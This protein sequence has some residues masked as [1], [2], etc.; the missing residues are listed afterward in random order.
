[1]L[2]LKSYLLV[3]FVIVLLNSTTIVNIIMI[4]I[5]TVLYSAFFRLFGGLLVSLCIIIGSCN[6]NLLAQPAIF[7]ASASIQPGEAIS[8]EG[9]FSAKAQAYIAVGT[10]S[11]N[12]S[13]PILV[14][15][16]GHLTAQVPA[17]LT[18]DV[19][20]VWVSDLGQRS[21]SVYINQARGMH[22]NSPE[23]TPGGN[24]QLF[25][26]NLLLAGST[27]QVRFSVQGGSSS[28]MAQVQ[29]V[30][31][32]SLRIT[33][34]SSLQPGQTYDVYVSNG[35]GGTAGETRVDQSLKAIATGVDYFQL[36]VAWA[37][38]LDFYRNIYNIRTDPRLPQKAIGN[39]I[40][41]DLPALQAAV[42]RASADGG[43]IVFLP[44]GIYKLALVGGGG[45]YMRNRVVIQGASKAGTILRYGYG[46]EAPGWKADGRWGLI[47]DS[48]IQGGL[49]DLTLLNIDNTGNFYNN[50]TGRGTEV[51][52][53]RVRFDLNL[54]SWLW[55]QG[56]NKV[57]ISNSEFTQGVDRL[58][59][60]HGLLQMNN[61]QNFV[62]AHNSFTYAVDG[63]NLNGASQGVFEDNQVNRDGSA[64][65]PASLNLVNHVLILNFAED[66]AILQNQFKVINGPAQ[67]IND[68]ET[69]IAEGGGG[70]GTRIDEDAG[71]ASGATAMTLQDNSKNWP[72]IQLHPVVAI[73]RGPGMGQ[74]RRIASRT[75]TTLTVDRAWDVVPTSASRYAIFNWGSRSWIIQGNKMEGNQRGIT[76]Y[77]NATADIAIVDNTLINNGSIDLT[78]W[79]M[80]N[81]GGG[82]P[83]EFLPMYDVQIVGNSV[84]DID[85]SNGVFIGVHTVQYIQPRSFGTSVIGLEV[86]RN[87]LVAH[88]PNVPAVVDAVFPEGYLNDLHFQPWTSN[89]IDE[90]TPAVLG[91]IF[92]DNIA[93][94]CNNA[95]YTNS[96]SYNT[97]V[98]NMKLVN[99]PNLIKD[100][101]FDGVNHGAVSTTSCASTSVSTG[102]LP[103]N[104]DPKTNPVIPRNVSKAR[105][106][107]LTGSD[108]DPNGKVIGFTLSS[109]PDANQGTVLVDGSPAK[110]NTWVPARLAD[111]LTF[112][113]AG[114]YTGHATFTYTATNDRSLISKAAPFVVPIANPLPVELVQFD[115]KAQNLDV[116][117]TWRTASSLGN[118]HFVVERSFD[119]K[120]YNAVGIVYDQGT[121]FTYYFT[122]TSV[123]AQATSTIYYRLQQVDK[124]GTI[125]YSPVQAVAF[126]NLATAIHIYPNP[127]TGKL[128]MQLP[129]VGAHVAIYSTAGQLMLE[130]RTSSIEHTLN[131]EALPAGVYLL[132]VQPDQ[133][134]RNSQLF[135]K[136][137]S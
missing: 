45:L 23:I 68:G 85:G 94:N 79:Q 114:N 111:A 127:T 133:G 71:T 9:Q 90:Q 131:I 8:L 80:E 28:S 70:G 105:L 36:G 33:A 11:V 95:L 44:D 110:S 66:V 116:L 86:R 103:P 59:G 3:V 121:A 21:A 99:S 108:P 92:Q 112:Q 35:L 18:L 91:S 43:G 102:S 96:G 32:Y 4:K 77:Q 40:A 76:F 60:Y 14:Q 122:D 54:G 30:D 135:V 15:S 106:L 81:V 5:L 52:F 46:T 117:L 39:G 61:C 47:W 98:C 42:D 2:Q 37:A 29:A 38:K 1:M 126:A 67:N 93:V 58:A 27:P 12:Q 53:Q 82:V 17:A 57:V 123:G 65:W 51:F 7:H 132:Q 89:Y 118:D 130:L 20:Q 49:A 125:T 124:D 50:M 22:F 100:S 78:P 24:I 109:L 129:T 137:Q 128:H 104:A 119:S 84:S 69:I 63:L 25:G 75:A 10:S 26:R 34:P 107:A 55:W 87:T 6:T 16:P 64:R 113:P 136:E 74:W 101:K 48:T 120:Q 62:I 31:A 72:A 115:A 41:N 73:V 13:L 134:P 83:Q 88:S 19:Y 97:V 56:S